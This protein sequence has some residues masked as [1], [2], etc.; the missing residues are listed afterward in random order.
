MLWIF[1]IKRLANGVLPLPLQFIQTLLYSTNVGVPVYIE[2]MQIWNFV[3]AFNNLDLCVL[4]HNLLKK[5]YVK[6]I[7]WNLKENPLSR[8]INSLSLS[9]SLPLSLSHSRSLKTTFYV[10]LGPVNIP[11]TVNTFRPWTICFMSVNLIEVSGLHQNDT[12]R[13]GII[14]GA[15]NL[16]NVT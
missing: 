8:S 12:W 1:S 2:G 13:G 3:E 16:F 11:R 4:H 9:H 6:K 10:N 15:I 7:N 5:H 14:T